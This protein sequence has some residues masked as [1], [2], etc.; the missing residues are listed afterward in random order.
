MLST[1][2]VLF[3]WESL[4]LV[5]KLHKSLLRL[6][7]LHDKCTQ[8]KPH[9]WSYIHRHQRCFRHHILAQ[10]SFHLHNVM[11]KVVRRNRSW[12][13]VGSLS[14]HSCFHNSNILQGKV[15]ISFAGNHRKYQHYIDQVYYS[16]LDLPSIQFHIK[17]IQLY[18]YIAHISIL[19]LVCVHIDHICLLSRLRHKCIASPQPQN[20]HGKDTAIHPRRNLESIY[21]YFLLP[22]SN[23]L[24][25]KSNLLGIG[26][27][28]MVTMIFLLNKPNTC[29]RSILFLQDKHNLQGNCSKSVHFD[30]QCRVYNFHF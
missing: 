20:L 12:I 16:L 26:I 4:L 25:R 30:I 14:K 1:E 21:I 19:S 15:S 22:S 11:Y 17:Y 23:E 8:V 18:I 9:N 24:Q 6:E 13:K 28:Q 27:Q 3:V 10:I 7:I 29:L 5:R 2:S